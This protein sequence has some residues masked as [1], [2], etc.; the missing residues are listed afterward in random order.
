MIYQRLIILG[1][2]ITAL[3]VA[4]NAR[5]LSLESLVIDTEA[6]PATLSSTGQSELVF[7]RDD[8]HSI[9]RILNLGDES[10]ALIATSDYWIQFVADHEERLRSN[11]RNIL[12]PTGD[13]L[14]I[15]L[16]KAD[17]AGWCQDSRI[18]APGFFLANEDRR[19]PRSELSYPMILRPAET[20]HHQGV[21]SVPKAIELRDEP[22]L[23][24]WLEMYQKNGVTPFLSESLL[25]RP[26]TQFSVCIARRGSD[27]L[28][29]VTRKDRPAPEH[30]RV[31]TYVTTCSM[32]EIESLGRTV[33]QRL[34]LQGIA[35]IEILHAV[36]TDSSYVIEV[37]PRPW[38]QYSLTWA[39]GKDFLRYLLHEKPI[40]KQ[41]D[42][43]ENH[44]WLNF[45][46]DLYNCFSKNDGIVRTGRLGMVKYLRSIARAD[47]YA[48]FSIRDIRPAWAE[49]KTTAQ[50]FLGR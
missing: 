49:L 27:I 25:H 20:L 2:S 34:D 46:A 17:F 42:H 10:S 21:A 18:P 11:Y 6:G 29:L 30:C 14:R 48:Y 36:D 41:S 32:P 9:D 7:G 40:V 45:R 24:G 39:S 31:G 8:E 12:H 50:M 19:V 13:T 1:S 28:S 3:A 15:C 43:V 37:N 23:L 5:A 38:L 22:E 4:R 35:E 47:S 44:S 33:A 26:L 16:S